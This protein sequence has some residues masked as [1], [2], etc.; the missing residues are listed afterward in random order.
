MTARDLLNC[1][2]IDLYTFIPRWVIQGHLFI[3]WLFTNQDQINNFS[4]WEM[5]FLLFLSFVQGFHRD[6]PFW[7][8]KIWLRRSEPIS[9]GFR[10]DN[11]RDELKA[12]AGIGVLVWAI[13]I[14]IKESLS[15]VLSR[16]RTNSDTRQYKAKIN[17]LIATWQATRCCWLGVAQLLIFNDRNIAFFIL[18][19]CDMNYECNQWKRDLTFSNVFRNGYIDS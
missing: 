6:V 15:M 8:L 13:S 4:E 1:E 9:C 3:H 11:Q 19:H 2:D 12:L 16:W 10:T 5:L 18:H 14:P 7:D 17:Q